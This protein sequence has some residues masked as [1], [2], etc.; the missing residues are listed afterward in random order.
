MNTT[1]MIEI[2]FLRKL[3]SFLKVELV[4]N[5]KANIR[6]GNAKDITIVNNIITI[7]NTVTENSSISFLPDNCL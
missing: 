6:I 3:K 2:D 7:I 4:S 1:P 5:I